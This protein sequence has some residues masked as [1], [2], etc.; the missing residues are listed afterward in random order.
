MASFRAKG[1]TF[2]RI[3]RGA[4]QTSITCERFYVNSTVQKYELLGT[5]DLLSFLASIWMGSFRE[6]SLLRQSSS[7]TFICCLGLS[8]GIRVGLPLLCSESNNKRLQHRSVRLVTGH[9]MRGCTLIAFSYRF[10]SQRSL[11]RSDQ[12][13]PIR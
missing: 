7:Y 11:A 13:S 9:K 10:P 8:S 12:C 1:R 3:D 5:R 6:M 4:S 2:M